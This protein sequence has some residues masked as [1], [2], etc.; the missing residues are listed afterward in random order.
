MLKMT[1]PQLSRSVAM[2][3][4]YTEGVLWVVEN[5]MLEPETTRGELSWYHGLEGGVLG[6]PGCAG[7]P[8]ENRDREPGESGHWLK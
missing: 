4:G 5:K 1:S 2:T 6:L 8:R 7:T 3:T